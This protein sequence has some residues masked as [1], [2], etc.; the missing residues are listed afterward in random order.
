VPESGEQLEEVR[1][2]REEI[3]EED[4]SAGPSPEISSES[5]DQSPMGDEEPLVDDYFLPF[6]LRKE[7]PPNGSSSE[8]ESERE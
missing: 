1:L 7:A 3:P 8:G 5:V 2:P 6:A 4:A